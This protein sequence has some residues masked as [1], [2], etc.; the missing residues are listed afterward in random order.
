MCRD[1]TGTVEGFER[2]ETIAGLFRGSRFHRN[3][4]GIPEL[5][6][7]LP[8]AQGASDLDLGFEGVGRM[9]SFEDALG[10]DEMN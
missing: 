9:H 10:T 6:N 1:S 3:Y 2:F 4:S 5:F 8:W 7:K